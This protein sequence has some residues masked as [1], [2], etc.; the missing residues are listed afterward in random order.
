MD[1]KVKEFFVFSTALVAALVLYMLYRPRRQPSKLS[2]RAGGGDGAS[3]EGPSLSENSKPPG[4]EEGTTPEGA[5]EL[6]VIFQFNGHSF[7]AY[8][9]LGLPA[10]SSLEKVRETYESAVRQADTESRE[11][12]QFAYA[13][14]VKK[15]GS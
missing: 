9:V 11:F 3:A 15:F 5:V 13:A 12:L 14:I 7:E 8:E 1:P 4:F 6:S 2:M 10:G